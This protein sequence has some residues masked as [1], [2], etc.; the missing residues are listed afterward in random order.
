MI[1]RSPDG[2]MMPFQP[3]STLQTAWV[4]LGFAPMGFGKSVF[5]NAM[6]NAMATRPG[7]ER[8]PYI[9]ILDIGV[10]SAGL[11]SLLKY[12]LPP[13]QRHLVQYYRLSNQPKDAINVF[14]T[15][16]GLRHPLNEH[17]E[18]L[19]SFITLLATPIGETKPYD[20]VAGI[21]R[22]IVDMVYETL[23]DQHNPKRYDPARFPEI[24]RIVKGLG[25]PLDE[26]TSWFEV[27]DA[28]FS[29]GYVH[30]A[31]LTHRQAMPTL[32]DCAATARHES[33]ASIYRDVTPSGLPL[34]DYV[35][36]SLI[37]AINKYPNLATTTAFDIG[38]SRIVSLDLQ[39]VAPSGGPQADRQTAI[40]YMVARRVLGQKLFMLMDDVKHFPPIYREYYERHIRETS[41]D[42]KAICMDEFHR[43][44][45]AQAVRDQVIRDIREGRKWKVLISLFSQLPEDFD[46]TMIDLATSVFI[47]GAGSDEG[48]NK[49]ASIFGLSNTELHIIK[50]RIRK[51]GRHGSSMLSIHKTSRGR[52]SQFVYLTLAPEEMW[53]YSTT[54]EDRRIRDTLYEDYDPSLVRRVLARMYPGGTATED[55]ERRRARAEETGDTSDLIE[56]IIH[57]LRG[58]IEEELR[59]GAD[60]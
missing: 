8:L 48:A 36:R 58:R 43:T 5:L 12:A 50:N 4:T 55:I 26:E 27:T 32:A 37:E 13:H 16:T 22:M 11:I 3:G 59:Q 1:L 25:I 23:D 60:Q 42:V 45:G 18:F 28:L 41:S 51:P 29:K 31:T 10:S 19:A 35:W 46:A 33:I 17:R 9:M 44:A 20:G 7:I 53:A 30:E 52:V 15:P 24:H 2:K 39:D 38:E 56:T 40:M 47:L 54:A 6:N 34:S 57:E 21:A 14:D 49:V